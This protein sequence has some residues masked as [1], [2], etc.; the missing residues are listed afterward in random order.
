MQRHQT[1]RACPRR[2]GSRGF[3]LIE[4]LVVIAIIAL[5]IGIL[6]PALG[7]ARD[8]ARDLVCKTNMRSLGQ[9]LMLYANDW[10]GNFPPDQYAEPFDPAYEGRDDNDGIGD[11][12]LAYWYDIKRLGQYIPQ[13][14]P[15]D[16]PTLGYETLGGEIMV[17][18]MHPEGGR[19]YSINAW[20]SSA[21]T[22]PVGE[23]EFGRR[24]KSY[25]GESTSIMLVGESWGQWATTNQN[26]DTDM[27]VT[28]SA[29]GQKPGQNSS[30][31]PIGG[32]FGGG[33][34]VRDWPGNALGGGLVGGNRAP[35]FGPG[36]DRPTSYIPWYRHPNRRDDPLAI[37]GG[38]NFVYVG[39]NVSQERVRDLIDEETG[40]STFKV[41]WSPFDREAEPD[42]DDVNP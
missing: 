23:N 13:W 35:E 21:G 10:D 29:V 24:F 1:C 14:A 38:A 9:A 36:T 18:P 41:L 28:A 42:E 26:D 33:E 6:L 37:E 12:V 27:Y 30:T 25:V 11:T 7:K 17:C 34:G 8:S 40:R 2:D 20:A 5:L 19:S 22:S 32:R 15:G 16:D 39:N 31:N 4:L 3:T